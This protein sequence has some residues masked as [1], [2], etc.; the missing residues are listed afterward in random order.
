LKKY[1]EPSLRL[2]KEQV[3]SPGAELEC[4]DTIKEDIPGSLANKHSILDRGKP[5]E[6]CWNEIKPDVCFIEEEPK[7]ISG[8]FPGDA[9]LLM[10]SETLPKPE[11]ICTR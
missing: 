5:S 2:E 3:P 8:F 1:V 11:M 6:E 9:K 4:D 10:S 7:L